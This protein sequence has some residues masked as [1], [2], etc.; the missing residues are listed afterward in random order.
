MFISKAIAP[1]MEEFSKENECIFTN[2][3]ITRRTCTRPVEQLS[4]ERKFKVKNSSIARLDSYHAKIDWNAP[5]F[6]HSNCYL[7]YNPG[8]EVA[9][10]RPTRSSLDAFQFKRNCFICGDVGSIEP[11]KK[12]P[13]R[14]KKNKGF[15]CRTADRGKGKKHLRSICYKSAVIV[16]MS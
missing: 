2:I 11:D 9:A 5:L 4:E 10:K 3:L 7:T 14:W 15:L 8:S 16:V 12:H 13:D 1:L 6:F